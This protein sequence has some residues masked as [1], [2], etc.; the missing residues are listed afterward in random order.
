M[1]EKEVE[2][3]MRS[4]RYSLSPK[5]VEGYGRYLGYFGEWLR[6]A[7]IQLADLTPDHVYEF[8]DTK[9][10]WSDSSRWNFWCA[11][12]ALL[13]FIDDEHHLVIHKVKIKRSKPEPQRTLKTD[14][15]RRLVESID[16]ETRA[17]KRDQALIALML[18]TGLRAAEV[19]RL[20]RDHVDVD[21]TL[22]KVRVKGNKWSFRRFGNHTAMILRGWLKYRDET[23][24]P[25]VETFFIS[26]GGTKPGSSLTPDGLRAIFRAMGRRAGIKGLSPHVMRRTMATELVRDGQ[27]LKVIKELGGW[28]DLQMVIRYTQAFTVEDYN[29]PFPSDR[30]NGGER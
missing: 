26:M 6:S 4:V 14:E 27:S 23:A 24:M 1:F 30:A 9:P 11:L 5:T 21:E 13:T 3:Y 16:P 12:K 10:H 19:C 18:D 29:G 8:L 20:K 7:Q 15:V 28:S 17:G 25:D 2:R 22:L